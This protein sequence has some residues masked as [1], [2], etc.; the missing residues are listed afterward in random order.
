MD[1]GSD[2][3]KDPNA[4]HKWFN[5]E[6]KQVEDAKADGACATKD[7]APLPDIPDPRPAEGVPPNAVYAIVSVRLAAFK[8]RSDGKLHPWCIPAETHV[9]LDLPGASEPTTFREIGSGATFP[10]PWDG[11]TR[12]PWVA[13]ATIMWTPE[14]E[15]KIGGRPTFT[16]NVSSKY[17]PELD[18]ET[19]D[20]PIAYKCW[21]TMNRMQSAF[22]GDQTL[23]TRTKDFIQCRVTTQAIPNLG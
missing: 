8:L 13:D 5:P 4:Y 23:D 10:V 3:P 19:D 12:T 11:I 2:A 14:T 17:I 16:I 7:V 22:A 15:K 9:Y 6:G 1:S 21:V 18:V 20:D